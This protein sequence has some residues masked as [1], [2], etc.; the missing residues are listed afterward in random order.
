MTGHPFTPRVAIIGATGAVGVEFLQLFEQRGFQFASLHLLASPRSAGKHMDCRG[1][2]HTVRALDEASLKDIDIALFSAGASVSREFGPIAARHGALVVDNSS[3]FRMTDGVPLVVPEVN[4]TDMDAAAQAWRASR[5]AGTSSGGSI[6]AN[7][8]CSTII[9]LV[10]IEPLRQ[11]FG[12]A[13]AVVSTYQ[14]VSGAGA[15]AME[16]LEQQTRDVLAG[17]S[18][19]PV[20]FQERCAFNIFSHN[21][22]VD[23]H[24]GR[25]VEEQKMIDETRKIWG[26]DTVQIAPTCVRVP[27]MRAHAESITLTLKA[28]ASEA[29]VRSALASGQGLRLVDDRASNKFPT[30]I[31]AAGIDEVLVGR[32][33]P[34]PTQPHEGSGPQARYTGWHLFV[35]GDQLRKGAALNAVQIAERALLI[36]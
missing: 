21:S 18:A 35:C 33:R 17:K 23:P 30:P 29:D 19:Q 12:V 13:R 22:K 1:Q 15:S 3:A 34:D 8:N 24:T 36:R 31:D 4:G 10:P 9:L 26:D 16:E 11:R 6:I 2:R 5:G 14:A 32:I 25:N 27:V 20:V 28:P 7:P